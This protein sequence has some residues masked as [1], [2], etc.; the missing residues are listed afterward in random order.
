MAKIFNVTAVFRPE[1]DYM[2]NIDGYLRAAKEMVD[3]GMYFIINKAR[4]YGKTTTLRSLNRF[5]QAEYYVV[6]ID[7]QTFGNAKFKSEN[8]FSLAFAHSFLRAL[9]R[10]ALSDKSTFREAIVRLEGY[11]NDR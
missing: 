8:T 5:L 6:L 7:F 4:Q 1:Q 10:N 9:K 3:N 2:V 11:I